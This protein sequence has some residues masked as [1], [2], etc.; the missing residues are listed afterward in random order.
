MARCCRERGQGRTCDR[1][2]ACSRALLAGSSEE[3]GQ[4]KR[5]NKDRRE[6]P[7]RCCAAGLVTQGGG[8]GEEA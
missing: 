4:G 8:A 7:G 2:E 6:Q 3:E 5:C 1:D